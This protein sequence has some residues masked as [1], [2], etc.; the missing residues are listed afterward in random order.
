MGSK[1]GIFNSKIPSSGAEKLMEIEV[2][3]IK[4]FIDT[5]GLAL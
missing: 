4:A 2:Y 3:I 1:I 5:I